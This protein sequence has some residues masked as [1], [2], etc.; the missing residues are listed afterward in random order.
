MISIRNLYYDHKSHD[1]YYGHNRALMNHNSTEVHRQRPR[2]VTGSQDLGQG[3]P[4]LFKSR[5]KFLRSLE[6]AIKNSIFKLF[7]KWSQKG[8]RVGDPVHDLRLLEW[9]IRPTLLRWVIFLFFVV[10]IIMFWHVVIGVVVTVSE[11]PVWDMSHNLRSWYLRN[12]S[13]LP[14]FIRRYKIVIFIS[15]F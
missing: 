2:S 13:C 6:L 7:E 1:R 9:I 11:S 4:T 10:F 12:M 5:E 15:F 14:L 8:E 3:L